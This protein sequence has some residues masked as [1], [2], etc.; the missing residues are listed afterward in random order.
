MRKIPAFT[1]MELAIAML[2]SAIVISLAYTGYSLLLRQYEQHSRSTSADSE[3]IFFD[4]TFRQDI[5]AAEAVLYDDQSIICYSEEGVITYT[6]AEDSL[7]IRHGAGN[8]TLRIGMRNMQVFF[9][10]AIQSIPG[11]F[12]DDIQVEVQLQG[13][14]LYLRYRKEYAADIL[15][16]EDREPGNYYERYRHQQI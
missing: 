6:R 2:L 4:H 9:R 15:I 8:D 14:T 3:L 16:R 11:L 12:C 10:G 5:A 7:M 1:I 13:E